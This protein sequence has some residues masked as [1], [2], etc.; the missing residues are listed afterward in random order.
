MDTDRIFQQ[1]DCSGSF[2]R[3]TITRAFLGT[4]MTYALPFME[5]APELDADLQ[6]KLSVVANKHEHYQSYKA[7]IRYFPLCWN[8]SL[9]QF[10]GFVI[11]S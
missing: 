3:E 2:G 11:K 6:K 4:G 10:D 9:I 7:R 5:V 1:C 8:W